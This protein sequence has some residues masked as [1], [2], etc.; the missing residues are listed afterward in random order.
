MKI[1]ALPLPSHP[2]HSV[3][4]SSK[5][6]EYITC[7]RKFLFRYLLGIVPDRPNH[8]LIFGSAWHAAREVLLQNS[9]HIDSV[10]EAYEAFSQDF[11]EPSF[12]SS[13]DF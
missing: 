4:D 2:T 5:I 13:T 12:P 8:N 11:T 7:E 1:P 9:N 10:P 3:L 6:S